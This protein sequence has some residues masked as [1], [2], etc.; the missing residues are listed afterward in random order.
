MDWDEIKTKDVKE[1]KELLSVLREEKRELEFKAHS[2]QLKQVHR[3]QEVK[4]T[5]ARICTLLTQIAGK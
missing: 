2:R 3:L 1:L 4:K 5:I